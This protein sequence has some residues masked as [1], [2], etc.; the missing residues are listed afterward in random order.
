MKI[1][2]LDTTHAGGVIAEHYALAG[3]EVIAIDVYHPNISDPP[4]KNRYAQDAT[5]NFD[6]AV[7]P[8]HMP[9]RYLKHVQAK[10]VIS[11]HTA[12]G[13]ILRKKNINSIIFEIT[14]TRSKTTTALTLSHLL[15]EKFNVVTNTSAGLQFN[16]EKI[17][18]LSTAPG[19][20]LRAIE[21]TEKMQPDVYIFEISLGGTGYADFGVL[22]SI[23]DDYLVADSTVLASDAKVKTII[24]DKTYP[25]V[26]ASAA[27]RIKKSP[28]TIFGDTGSD[29][30]IQN[31]M[32]YYRQEGEKGTMKIPELLEPQ[33]YKTGIEAAVAS[34]LQLLT[35]EEIEKRL[36]V[37]T[38]VEGR[39][40]L[41]DIDGRIFI[42]NSNSG[43]RSEELDA[44][45]RKAAEY[46][47]VF[48]IHGED[49]KVCERLNRSMSADVMR[50][51]KDKLIGA[52]LIG[53][54]AENTYTANNIDE[55]LTISLKHTHAGDVIFSHVKCFR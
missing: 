35:P 50:K 46:G 13:D 3:H 30:Y 24:G 11:H 28:K 6:L 41:H 26:H 5:G 19:N 51:W 47:E 25:I 9:H 39:M 16:N 23:N 44:L 49:G 7:V 32:L 37:F 27:K 54:S 1:A 53:F 38:G 20:V 2:V 22:T 55:A 21:L 29:V 34:A 14:G 31:D 8:V 48:L 4:Y 52:V 33:A 17:T 40:C 18:K 43:V 15:Q 10:H 36:S 42:D 12:V 45:L